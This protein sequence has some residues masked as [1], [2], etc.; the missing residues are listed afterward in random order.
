MSHYIY[1]KERFF[2]IHNPV[3][4][5]PYAAKES[6]RTWSVITDYSSVTNYGVHVI[7]HNWGANRVGEKFAAFLKRELRALADERLAL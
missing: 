7:H 4:G 6:T 5:Q 1:D 3:H 2:A